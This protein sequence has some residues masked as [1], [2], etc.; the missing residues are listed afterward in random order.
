[1]RS[2]TRTYTVIGAANLLPLP[3]P[4]SRAVSDGGDVVRLPS[5]GRHR[6]FLQDRSGAQV[7]TAASTLEVAP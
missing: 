5:A 7:R 2:S 3:A 1:M 4:A 6:L